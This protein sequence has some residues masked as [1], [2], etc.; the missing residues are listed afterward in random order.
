MLDTE[1]ATTLLKWGIE[2]AGG[3]AQST[4]GMDD[5]SAQ[6]NMES[7]LKAVRQFMRAV[8]NWAAG[9]Y[10][11]SDGRTI[12]KNKLLEQVQ[13]MDLVKIRIPT[14]SDLEKQL[15]VVR[16]SQVQAILGLKDFLSASG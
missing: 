4:E 7:R 9:N 15:T 1:A 13:T 16:Q 2:L 8:G 6:V 5:L 14:G 3:I 10:A 12:L 11:D